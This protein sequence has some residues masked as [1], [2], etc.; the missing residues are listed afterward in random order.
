[1]AWWIDALIAVGAGVLLAWLLLIGI[2]WR[3]G[4]ARPDL[5][6]AV[7]LLPDLVRLLSRLARDRSLSRGVRVR[8]WLLLGY[9]VLP[10]DIVPDFL[11]VIGYA[12]DAIIV[13]LVLR[14]VVRRAGF[15]AL[16]THWPGTPDGLRAVARIAGLTA[17]RD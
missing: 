11:P 9:L 6:D 2:L 15:E 16:E 1:M 7:R 12:D 10:I 4:R 17:E 14:S 3:A 5:L 8:L 13:G